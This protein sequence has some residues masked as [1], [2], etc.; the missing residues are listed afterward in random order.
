[1]RFE[2]VLCNGRLWAAVYDG[3]DTDVLSRKGKGE[4]DLSSRFVAAFIC[5]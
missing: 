4:E 2:D 5:N 1:M 3:D